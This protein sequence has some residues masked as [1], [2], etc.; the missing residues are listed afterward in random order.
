M[1]RLDKADVDLRTG[2]LL[3]RRTKFKKDRIVPLHPTTREVLRRYAGARDVA[4]EG[5]TSPAFFINLRRQR[6]ASHTLE[7][8]TFKL[9]LRAGL[10]GP[11]GKGPSFHSLRHTF[12]VRRLI[13][14]YQQGT[15]V[16]AML[17]ALATYMGHVCY[18]STAY[19]ITATAE[20]MRLAAG[21]YYGRAPLVRV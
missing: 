10:R 6:F 2:V 4:F 15:D 13:A 19:Y 3:I 1:V 12:A 21:R 8:A 16:Q 9:L 7:C 18:S 20:L 14:W 11:S 17:P 5:C